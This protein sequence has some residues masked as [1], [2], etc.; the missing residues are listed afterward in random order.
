MVLWDMKSRKLAD[1]TT[2]FSFVIF[3]ENRYYGDGMTFF[4]ADPNLPLLKDIKEGGGLGLVNVE[5]VLNSTQ[6][7]FVAVEF[8]NSRSMVFLQNLHP[9]RNLVRTVAK[10]IIL[11]MCVKRNMGSH[12][13]TSSTMVKEFFQ[14]IKHGFAP[15][16]EMCLT[17]QQY[18]A[19]LALL[20]SNTDVAAISN[21]QIGS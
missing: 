13:V 10:L 15:D 2:K 4:L 18:Q 11:L 6:H 1:F 5:Q 3:S 19:L 20:N 16:H 14:E 8:D 9:V 12:L 17:K 21:P 7:P